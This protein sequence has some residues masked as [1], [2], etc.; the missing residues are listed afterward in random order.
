MTQ[1]LR[2][3]FVS[4]LRLGRR[5]MLKGSLAAAAAGAAPLAGLP[6]PVLAQDA[7][8]GAADGALPNILSLWGDDIGWFNVSAYNM[9]IMGYRTPNIDR[10]GREGM[11][12]TDWYG[13]N[14]CTAGC[15]NNDFAA[16]FVASV[17][18]TVCDAIQLP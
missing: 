3:D 18:N 16:V 1:E 12:C 10:I 15:D 7:T 4:D 9:G 13:Q 5:S 17:S 14:S 11:V 8:P 6:T 2:A